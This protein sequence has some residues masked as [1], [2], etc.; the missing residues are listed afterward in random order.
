MEAQG[1]CEVIGDIVEGAIHAFLSDNTPAK[2]PNAPYSNGTAYN[3]GQ[4]IGHAAA[5]IQGADEMIQGG[6]A[7]V[8]GVVA[9]PETGTASLALSAGGAVV[10]THGAWV[11][12]N[13][14]TN[15]LSGNGMVYA[16]AAPANTDNKSKA[17]EPHGNSHSS[18]K[19]QHGYSIRDKEGNVLEYGISGQ[20]AK[21]DA[22]GVFTSSPRIAQKL[23]TK[24]KGDNNV[25]GQFE[26]WIK[27]RSDA[28]QWEENQ[29]SNYKDNNNGQKPPRQIRP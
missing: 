1:C 23:R 29:V 14:I 8:A 6:N 25:S 3:V 20:T 24:Y 26:A 28:V 4:S 18:Q 11:G 27:N 22:T 13:A 10:A 7:V 19:Q 5:F 12:S 21:R 9:A 17:A 2:I 16:N 15:L